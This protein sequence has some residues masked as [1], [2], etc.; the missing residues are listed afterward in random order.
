MNNLVHQWGT[1]FSKVSD[2]A[3]LVDHNGQPYPFTS[4]S[5]RHTFVFWCLNQDI[6]T[7]DIAML[8]GDS[9]EVVAKYY[10]VWIHGRQERLTQR[11]VEALKNKPSKA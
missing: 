5:M 1:L 7:E 3:G 9:V 10:S 6:P 2:L 8:I 4:H 11:M